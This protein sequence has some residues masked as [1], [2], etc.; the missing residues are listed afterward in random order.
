MFVAMPLPCPPVR[1]LGV[2]PFSCPIHIISSH[3]IDII[4]SHLY[5]I[6]S[7]PNDAISPLL[8]EMTFPRSHPVCTQA[9]FPGLLI[10]YFPAAL[11]TYM[12]FPPALICTS[13]RPEPRASFPGLGR[14]AAHWT[15]DNAATWDNLRWSITGIVNSNI[16]GMPL[17]GADICGTWQYDSTTLPCLGLS[18]PGVCFWLE[19]SCVIRLA[20]WLAG[21]SW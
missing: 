20:I 13:S 10:L 18:A 3:P 12:Y 17:A 9:Y 21:L 1:T 8:V 16:W 2:I 11:S 14:Y 4:S 5:F 19:P 6:S 15:G 7:C